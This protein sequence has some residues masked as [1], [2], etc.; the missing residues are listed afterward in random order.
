MRRASRAR[1]C[2]WPAASTLP[3]VLLLGVD[4][5]TAL[6]VPVAPRRVDVAVRA[7]LDRPPATLAFRQ[8]GEPETQVPDVA[9][10]RSRD[11][12]T[13]TVTFRFKKAS[14]LTM[15]NVW[16]NGLITGLWLQDEEGQLSTEDVSVT[17]GRGK[18]SG[19]IAILVLKSSTEWERFMRFMKRYAEAND[20]GFASAEAETA[21]G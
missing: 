19:V 3:L 1:G 11:G 4:A 18:P 12:S 7:C 2:A 16:N 9:L 13:G 5:T 14:V 17:F 10:T 8:D 6:R 21:D 20:L 15:N